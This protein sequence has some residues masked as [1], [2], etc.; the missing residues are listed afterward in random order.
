MPQVWQSGKGAEWPPGGTKPRLGTPG[1]TICRGPAAPWDGLQGRA[2][3]PP[4]GHTGGI[5]ANCSDRYS[6]PGRPGC[7]A[8]PSGRALGP[9]LGL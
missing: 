2:W 5:L 4:H 9:G 1:V 8:R 7:R 3:M 6:S